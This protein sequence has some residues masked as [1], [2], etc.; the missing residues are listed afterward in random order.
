[1]GSKVASQLRRIPQVAQCYLEGPEVWAMLDKL[2]KVSEI[3]PPVKYGKMFEPAQY[4]SVIRIIDVRSSS[5]VLL[6]VVSVVDL[7]RRRLWLPKCH[8]RL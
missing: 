6:G 3:I 5:S 7:L 2:E 8:K 1:M 4:Q